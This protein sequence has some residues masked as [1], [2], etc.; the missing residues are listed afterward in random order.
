[1]IKRHQN[2]RLFPLLVIVCIAAVVVSCAAPAAPTPSPTATPT[3]TVTTPAP[4]PTPTPAPTPTPTPTATVPKP[5]LP[6]ATASLPLGKVGASYSGTLAAGGGTPPYAWSLASGSLPSGLNLAATGA[7]SGIPDST[8][9]FDFTVQVKD[10]A[11]PPASASGTLTITIVPAALSITTTTLPSLRT[12]TNYST[13]LD[14]SGGVRPYSWSLVS[15][16]LP[17]GLSLSAAGF[18]SGIPTSAGT[19]D[20]TVQ[21]SDSSAP[22]VGVQA[23]L[24][25][26]IVAPPI[27]ISTAL[28][29]GFVGLR[30]SATLTASGGV[31]PYSWSVVSGSLPPGLSLSPAG[32]ISGTPATLGTY[33]LTLGVADSTTPPLTVQ[34]VLT[35]TVS[36]YA[37]SPLVIVNSSLPLGTL[38]AS[39]TAPLVATGGVPPYSWTILSGNLPPG[40]GI[41]SAGLISGTP[42]FAGTYN[43]VV[44]V[45]DGSVSSPLTTDKPFYLI[46]V[47]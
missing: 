29:I 25:I 31:V 47:P 17:P 39:Y 46:V 18:I 1:M 43:L 6:L 44:Q 5:S 32:T 36:N 37:P 42:S 30:Y 45:R 8:G 33:S 4:T 40:L 14:A 38:G 12:G 24:S 22:A 13:S 10:S 15:G 26:I 3:P 7:I 9:T 19:S 20:F 11:S 16:S 27:T 35:I 28:P 34:Q 23:K 21:V 41:T 2:K